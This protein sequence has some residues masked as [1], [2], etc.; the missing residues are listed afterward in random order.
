MLLKRKLIISLI[1]IIKCIR[2]QNVMIVKSV[3]KIINQEVAQLLVRNVVCNK[4]KHYEIGCKNK[5]KKVYKT[6]VT[7]EITNNEVSAFD[8]FSVN[9][10]TEQVCNIDANQ[11]SWIEE[12]KIGKMWLKFKLDTGSDINIIPYDDFIKLEPQK[13]I[14]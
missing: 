3:V 13:K 2:Q 10:I 9:E 11:K 8:E 6:S 7:H 1:E 12:I 4:L 14:N 5:S